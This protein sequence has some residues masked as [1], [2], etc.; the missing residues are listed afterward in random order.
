[1]RGLRLVRPQLVRSV[2][3]GQRLLRLSQLEKKHAGLVGGIGVMRIELEHVPEGQRCLIE[4][5]QIGKELRERLPRL[6]RVDIELHGPVE[7]PERVLEPALA[8]R[9]VAETQEIERLRIL[10]NGAGKPFDGMIGLLGAERQQTQ[11]MHGF[12][13]IGVR[14][15]RPLTAKL[16]IEGAARLQMTMTQLAKRGRS[17]G[18]ARSRPVFL[19]GSPAFTTV[20]W[21]MSGT[22]SAHKIG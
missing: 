17:L 16:G 19:A 15:Q 13:A 6:D 9:G 14:R 7:S 21:R 22:E 20:H 8:S 11:Q 3:K 1:M 4:A 18:G 5:I 10:L 2:E 12:G